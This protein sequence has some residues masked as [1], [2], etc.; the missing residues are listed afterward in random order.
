MQENHSPKT[1]AYTSSKKSH[2]HRAKSNILNTLLMSDPLYRPGGNLDFAGRT[3]RNDRDGMLYE[4]S[5]EEDESALQESGEEEEEEE[6]EAY[7]KNMNSHAG[8]VL[9]TRPGR[10]NRDINNDTWV[11]KHHDGVQD[12]YRRSARM[13]EKPTSSVSRS[14]GP[15]LRHRNDSEVRRDLEVWSEAAKKDRIAEEN[16]QA[17]EWGKNAGE[18]AGSESDRPDDLMG[19]FKR[20]MDGQREQEEQRRGREPVDKRAHG[21]TDQDSENSEDEEESRPRKYVKRALKRGK[22]SSI[23]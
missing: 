9:P 7:A 11:P 20:Y 3:A 5:D 2:L 8:H 18:L 14:R 22:D 1:P 16:R 4:G 21:S 10:G 6:E 15:P 12:R 13:G 17:R 23:A 19:E